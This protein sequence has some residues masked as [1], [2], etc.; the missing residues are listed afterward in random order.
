[1]Y[2]MLQTQ[3]LRVI[4]EKEPYIRVNTRELNRELCTES[5]IFYTKL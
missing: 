5:S 1:M 3:E 4:Q 2:Y